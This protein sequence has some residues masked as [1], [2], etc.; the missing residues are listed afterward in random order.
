MDRTGDRP[1]S[2]PGLS[3][4]RQGRILC[5]TLDR[6]ERLN[7]IDAALHGAL[8]GAF[9]WSAGD[10]GSD[11]L[12]LTGAG[13][14]FSAG[15]D[16]EW[17][18][19]MLDD[20]EAWR[21]N[22]EE[23]GR[24]VRTLLALDKPLVTAVRGPAIGLGATL[25]AFSDLVIADPTARI[26]DPHTTIGLAAGDGG[27]LLWPHIIG[28][29]RTRELLLLGRTLD[30][31]EAHRIGLV[32]RIVDPDDLE[33]ET[34]VAAAALA[35]RSGAAVRATKRAY[36]MPLRAAFE[37]LIDAQLALVTET[38]ATPEHRAAVEAFLRRRNGVA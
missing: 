17:M 19:A 35:A 34:L 23:A 7:A 5:L 1:P 31:E 11:V 8:V 38:Q 10:D 4:D 36:M 25:L 3:A 16:I 2:F 15:G 14:A 27:S 29:A 28:L 6:P 32:S 20:P 18:A 33:E 13:T 24:L 37:P 26:G 21:I 9:E 12:L 30:A 22:V